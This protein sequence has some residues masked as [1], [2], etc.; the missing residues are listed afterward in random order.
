MWH[1][2]VGAGLAELVG[3]TA[4]MWLSDGHAGLPV[5]VSCGAAAAAACI[6]P[7]VPY[8]AVSGLTALLASLGLTAAVAGLVAWLRPERGAL[9]VAQTYGVLIAAAALCYGASLL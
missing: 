1:A 6:A 5:A 4:G 7:A 8:L 9:A 3:M 2:A